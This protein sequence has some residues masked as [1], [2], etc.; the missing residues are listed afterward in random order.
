MLKKLFGIIKHCLLG[1]GG[2]LGCEVMKTSYARSSPVLSPGCKRR[3]VTGS[4]RGERGAVLRS[5]C[6]AKL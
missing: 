4:L 5:S 2:A 6:E 3:R 1:D